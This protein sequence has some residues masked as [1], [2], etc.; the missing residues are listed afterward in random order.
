L[1]IYVEQ[2]H[3]GIEGAIQ[4]EDVI[5]SYESQ[6]QQLEQANDTIA[7]LMEQLKLAQLSVG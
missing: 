4:V 6:Q 3:R 1:P 7:T 2:E 5:G